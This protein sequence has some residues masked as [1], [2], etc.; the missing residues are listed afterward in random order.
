VGGGK[1]YGSRALV[2][3]GEEDCGGK[4]GNWLMAEIGPTRKEG[5]GET[6]VPK[7][8]GVVRKDK[9]RCFRGLFGGVE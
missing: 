6:G 8:S 1:H 4:L 3:S 5:T 7:I 9:K 2:D